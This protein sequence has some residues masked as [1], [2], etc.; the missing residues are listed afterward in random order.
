VSGRTF[1]LFGRAIAAILVAIAI[2]VGLAGPASAHNS[3][4]GSDPPDGAQLGIAP[5]Q[6]ALTFAKTVGLEELQVDFTDAAG[7]RSSLTGFAYGPAGQTTVLVPIPAASGAVSLRWKLVGPDGHT[8]SGRVGLTIVAVPVVATTAVPDPATQASPTTTAGAVETTVP[9]TVVSRSVSESSSSPSPV[10]TLFRWLLRLAAFLGLIALGGTIVT[11]ALL[12]RATWSLP[13][14]RQIAAW[15]VGLVIGSTVL[16]LII[17]YSDV[18]SVSVLLNT[19]YGLALTVR[20][21]L[22]PVVA[23]YLFTWFPGDD[24]K[25]WSWLAGGLAVVAATWSWSGHPRSLRW[26]PIG[27]PLDVVHML[28]AIA[29][30]G[31]LV[32]LGVVVMRLATDEEQVTA[33]KA[34]APVASRSVGALV[35]TGV[36]QTFRIDRGP[37]ALFTTAHG[38]LVL[39]KIIV[40]ALMLY[41]ANVNRKRVATRLRS[42]QASRG[43]RTML[44]RAMVTEA[45][46]GLAIVAVTA[47]LVVNS[48]PPG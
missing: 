35:V 14:V 31:G 41:V 8:V 46:I 37:G 40:V 33:V 23:V 19:S 39:V 17:F 25:R 45:A 22:M 47:I 4:V 1:S 10:G 44:R 16:S 5:A 18:G 11:S 15:G 43:L 9:V 6:L 13:M 27:V 32:F 20:V 12:W 36:L 48:P 2:I 21:V 3:F 30:I 7:I 29:W 34:F 42:N 38:R 28:A 24:L 26:P